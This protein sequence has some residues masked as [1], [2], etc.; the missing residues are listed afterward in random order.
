MNMNMNMFRIEKN[1][2]FL[3]PSQRF[4]MGIIHNCWKVSFSSFALLLTSAKSG[5]CVPRVVPLVPVAPEERWRGDRPVFPHTGSSLCW[6]GEGQVKIAR[7]ISLGFGEMS[8]RHGQV[9]V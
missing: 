5:R 4:T 9:I 8:D 3:V 7:Y 1:A 2:F 6:P